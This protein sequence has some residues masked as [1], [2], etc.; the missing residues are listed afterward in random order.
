RPVAASLDGNRNNSL[1][2]DKET[3]GPQIPKLAALTRCSQQD[4]LADFGERFAFADPLEH[5]LSPVFDVDWI[6]LN[7]IAVT[8]QIRFGRWCQSRDSEVECPLLVRT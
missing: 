1:M 7:S 4:V 3:S 2:P 6:R 5:A 8:L